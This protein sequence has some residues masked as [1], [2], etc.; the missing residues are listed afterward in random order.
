MRMPQHPLFPEARSESRRC[1]ALALRGRLPL[2]L[3]EPVEG[4][5]D[6]ALGFSGAGPLV[7]LDPLVRLEV[8]VVLEEVLDLL[9]RELRDVA[10][11]LDVRPA[12]VLA[13]HRDDLVVSACLVA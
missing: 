2:V 1:D 9:A 12:W 3:L 11:V 10:D 6:Q 7:D 5:A 8:L 4:L 13:E